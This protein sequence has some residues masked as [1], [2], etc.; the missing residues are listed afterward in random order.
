MLRVV[1]T[2]AMMTS[3]SEWH[4]IAV[5]NTAMS[6]TGD[7][8]F[9]PTRMTFQNGQ[10][11]ELQYL[12][13]RPTSARQ[14]TSFGDAAH[15]RLYRV[16]SQTNP[17]LRNG[18]KLCDSGPTFLTIAYEPEASQETT[19]LAAFYTGAAAPPQ[20]EESSTLCA[21]FTYALK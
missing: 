2:L 9:T 10:T 1:L 4:W 15:Y 12:A 19:V 14:R 13:M 18:N 17:T 5:S 3:Q 7:V 21:T 20:W 8:T 11:I 16:T 6:I